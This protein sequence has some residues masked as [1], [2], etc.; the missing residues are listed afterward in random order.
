MSHAI[1]INTKTKC[2]LNFSETRKR[3]WVQINFFFLVGLTAQC[4][5][6]CPL[7]S[8]R[9]L[10]QRRSVSRL[11]PKQSEAGIQANEQTL[12]F[13]C[14]LCVAYPWCHDWSSGINSHT[15][16]FRYNFLF[17]THEPKNG[18]YHRILAHLGNRATRSKI[19]K[20]VPIGV[21]TDTYVLSSI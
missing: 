10:K 20:L 5:R 16:N 17:K 14:K 15:S 1:Y 8:S 12:S 7:G 21:W 2:C 19:W 3:K 6:P 18:A 13:S 4:P 11:G 9:H